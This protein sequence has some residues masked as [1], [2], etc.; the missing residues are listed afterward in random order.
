MNGDTRS[1]IPLGLIERMCV[2]NILPTMLLKSIISRDIEFME[3]LGIYECDPE[4]FSLCSFIDASKMDIMSII[5]DGL[6]YVEME[7]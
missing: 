4:D 7:G 2:L 6:D 5:Q 3:N 1:I